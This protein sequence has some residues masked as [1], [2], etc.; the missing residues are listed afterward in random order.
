MLAF[1]WSFRKNKNAAILYFVLFTAF[2]PLAYIIYSK[3]NVYHAWRHVLFIFPSVM[4]MVA[5]GWQS[6]LLFFEKMKIKLVGFALLFFLAVE[7]A[8]FIAYSFPNTVT[9]HNQLVGGVKGA[10]GNYEVDYYYNSMKQCADWFKKNELPK[11]KSTDTIMIMSNA[12]H[13]LSKYFPEPKN[14]KMDYIRYAERNTKKWDYLIMHIALIPAEDI[15]S[16]TWMPASTVYKADIQGKTLCAVIKRPSYD[17]MKAYDF[18]QQNQIDSALHYF[19]LYLTKDS[20]NTS[21]L[22]MV[23][24]IYMQTNRMAEAEQYINRSYRID[25]SSMETKQMKGIL[26]LQKNDFATAQLLFSQLL[27]ENPQYAKGYF[28]LAIAQMN[29]GSLDAALSN[30][31]TASQDESVRTNCYR[32]MGD[33]YSKK[34]NQQQAM[35]FY[36]M[37]GMPVQP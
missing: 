19:N 32:Y 2:F 33:I 3:S 30:F 21:V 15:K 5:F 17:D 6:I 35:K 22:N 27:S 26:C 23:S 28:Y 16:G 7:P 18:L 11:Y 37:G 34:G 14:V 4:V 9:Y 10:Y 31:N 20:G 36:Q 8:W 1:L 29:L 13:L 25:S 12:V 24:N